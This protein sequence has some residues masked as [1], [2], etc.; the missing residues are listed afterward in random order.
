MK[1]FENLQTGEFP[2]A[3][4]NV[5]RRGEQY[6]KVECER[7]FSKRLAIGEWLQV[8]LRVEQRFDFLSVF[9]VQK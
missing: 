2:I 6:L 3:T 8:G 1:E 7:G 4:Q 9:V 5:E